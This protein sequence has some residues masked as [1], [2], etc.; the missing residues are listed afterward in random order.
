M[1]SMHDQGRTLQYLEAYQSLR[2][3]KNWFWWLMLL[4]VVINVGTFI[5]VRFWPVLQASPS[6]Q[7]TL[8]ELRISSQT[9]PT[10]QPAPSTESDA[11]ETFYGV[12]GVVLPLARSVGLACALLL[13]LSLLLSLKVALLG[14][15]G[16]VG[17]LTSSMLWGLV[18]MVLMVPW[19]AA[20]PGVGVPGVLFSRGGLVAATAEVTWGAAGVTWD[21]HVLYFVRFAAYPIVTVLIWLVVQLKYVRAIGQVST[22]EEPPAEPTSL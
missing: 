11:S 6:F 20:F 2:V 13:V 3:A 9:I 15:L 14:R 10:S 8:A 1:D 5:A 4:A 18:L 21:D 17:H 16:G 12:L 22:M 7:A 19:D